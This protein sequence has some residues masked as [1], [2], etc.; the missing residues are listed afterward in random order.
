VA[1]LTQ[2]VESVLNAAFALRG[3]TS[4]A[5]LGGVLL[6]VFWRK[7]R[8]VPVILGMATSLVAMVLISACWK[9]KIFWPWYTL[10]GT[11]VTLAIAFG[12]S[13]LI[14]RAP[15]VKTEPKEGAPVP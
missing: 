5:L 14:P 9:E 3:L 12:V 8:A 15:A 1:A 11:L 2:H 4:G 6:A 7:G 13:A 10:V